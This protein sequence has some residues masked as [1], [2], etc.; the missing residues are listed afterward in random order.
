[1][2]TLQLCRWARPTGALFHNIYFDLMIAY[3]ISR[4]MVLD[5]LSTAQLHSEAKFITAEVINDRAEWVLNA[6][7]QLVLV[8]KVIKRS[9][10]WK[11]QLKGF[12]FA[13]A[14]VELLHSH[15]FD[16]SF[17]AAQ[18]WIVHKRASEHLFFVNFNITKKNPCQ[19]FS[20]KKHFNAKLFPLK[21]SKNSRLRFWIINAERLG[22]TERNLH[23]HFVVLQENVWLMNFK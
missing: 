6:I 10:K 16:L 23:P 9:L 15:C 2:Q 1:M 3:M 11:N 14:T 5:D 18:S 20:R 19:S 4:I 22:R 13:K 8:S 21:N 17:P 7:R 12:F